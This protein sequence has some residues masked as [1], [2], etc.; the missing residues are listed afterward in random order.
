MKEVS[1]DTSL[2]EEKRTDT[3]LTVRL[4]K[5]VKDK[6]TKILKEKNLTPSAAVQRYFEVIVETGDVPLKRRHDRPSQEEI[7]QRLEAMGRFHTKT[8]LNMADADIRAARIR[9][10]YDIDPG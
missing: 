2:L 3:I 6:A 9:E 5:E 10:Q 7:R 4:K 1:M 8:P